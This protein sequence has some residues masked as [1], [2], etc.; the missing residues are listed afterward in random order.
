V[1]SSDDLIDDSADNSFNGSSDAS[2]KQNCGMML[3]RF[4]LKARSGFSSKLRLKETGMA[5][6]LRRIAF[7]SMT[8]VCLLVSSQEVRADECEEYAGF[9]GSGGTAEAA[10]DDCETNENGWMDA[11]NDA[12]DDGG[13]TWHGE[14]TQGACSSASICGYV[15]GQPVYCSAAILTC[16]REEY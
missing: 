8:I 11:C 10:I 14:L 6:V 7:A 1:S 5:K 9:T 15:G 12:C 2:S 4:E 3:V 16:Y 13:S